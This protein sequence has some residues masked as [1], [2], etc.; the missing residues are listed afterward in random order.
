MMHNYLYIF[1]RDA[2]GSQVWFE[3]I[4]V[5]EFRGTLRPDGT[6][7]GH[8]LCDVKETS[9]NQWFRTNDSSLPV[10]IRTSELSKFAYVV[11]YKRTE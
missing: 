7:E 2:T 10:P 6:S 11:L 3:P 9:S 1:C 5:S 4:A 8:Y